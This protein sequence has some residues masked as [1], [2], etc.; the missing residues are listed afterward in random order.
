M[1]SNSN[2]IGYSRDGFPPGRKRRRRRRVEGEIEIRRRRMG[3]ERQ[4]TLRHRRRDGAVVEN[5]RRESEMQSMRFQSWPNSCFDN[6]KGYHVA[7]Q[8]VDALISTTDVE[9]LKRAWR[10]EKAAP[11]RFFVEDHFNKFGMDICRDLEG[12]DEI[13]IFRHWQDHCRCLPKVQ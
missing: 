12:E 6:I 2:P 3:R 11:L 13:R 4:I 5:G 7:V 8:S 10:N 9:L 1:E